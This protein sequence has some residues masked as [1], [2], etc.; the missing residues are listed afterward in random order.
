MA[1]AGA[2][3]A[4]LWLERK[5]W[6][7]SGATRARVRREA[8]GLAGAEVA[9]ECRRV[10]AEEAEAEDAAGEVE[11]RWRAARGSVR[12]GM[13]AEARRRLAAE[14]EAE[15]RRSLE[16]EPRCRAAWDAVA[17]ARDADEDAADAAAAASHAQLAEAGARLEGLRREAK[18]KAEAK[19]DRRW[20]KVEAAARSRCE[21]EAVAGAE[22]ETRL[23]RE[24]A[25]EPGSRR[26]AAAEEEAM[27]RRGAEATAAP[28]VAP[29]PITERMREFQAMFPLLSEEAVRAVMSD[30]GED[31]S[32][33]EQLLQLGFDA[34]P[35]RPDGADPMAAAG[36][37]GGE[38]EHQAGVEA[39]AG[40]EAEAEAEARREVERAGIIAIIAALE[41]RAAAERGA[42]LAALAAVFG[43]GCAQRSPGCGPELGCGSSV[44]V[45]GCA[46]ALGPCRRAGRLGTT[47]GR[48]RRRPH[49]RWRARR[50]SY[51]IR[52]SPL[53]LLQQR[54]R[55]SIDVCLA[56]LRPGG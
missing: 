34:D 13:E 25:A 1:R 42:A 46:T 10:R 30:G 11:A 37:A 41:R 48:G 21:A 14:A 17:A 31:D 22:A 8:Q 24:A 18:A 56:T 23:R 36:A 28:P 55:G 51:Y 33:L 52:C 12:L 6:R 35:P 7:R 39:R 3:E 47:P 49:R 16:A 29:P 45:V 54:R 5:T 15:S 26:E 27:C 20:R 50:E 19:A 44:A 9:A 43:G 32:I 40:A 4:T 38:A 53:V 2:I